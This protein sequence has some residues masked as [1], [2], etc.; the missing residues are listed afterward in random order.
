MV[1]LVV[2][3]IVVSILTHDFQYEGESR[4]PQDNIINPRCRA[5]PCSV[6][7]LT[8]VSKEGSG[9]VGQWLF[10][11]DVRGVRWSRNGN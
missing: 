6:T 10:G 7:A 9:D 1:L 2:V 11:R 5:C 4:Y 3:M 8:G